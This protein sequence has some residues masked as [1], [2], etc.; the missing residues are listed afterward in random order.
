MPHLR[1]RFPRSHGQRWVKPKHR[2]PFGNRPRRLGIGQLGSRDLEPGEI[3]RPVIHGHRRIHANL[4]RPPANR[5]PGKPLRPLPSS[6]PSPPNHLP[7]PSSSPGPHRRRPLPIR[8]TNPRIVEKPKHRAG[9][10]F[11]RIRPRRRRAPLDP[12][13]ERQRVL[14]CFIGPPM[15]LRSR[16]RRGDFSAAFRRTAAENLPRRPQ[17]PVAQLPVGSAGC[18]SHRLRISGS[19]SRTLSASAFRPSR[20]PITTQYAAAATRL[21]GYRRYAGIGAASGSSA[22]D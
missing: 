14:R 8:V 4:R 18:V 1:H 22:G 15:T 11:K 6:P 21:R 9:G 2:R 16:G 20:R 3:R 13:D 5:D 10:P 17:L 19:I 12:D 7:N